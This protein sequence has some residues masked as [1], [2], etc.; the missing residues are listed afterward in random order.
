[1]VPKDV[2]PRE[3]ELRTNLFAQSWEPKLRELPGELKAMVKI[4]KKYGLR[5]EGLAFSRRILRDMPIWAHKQVN[6]KDLRKLAVK[7]ATTTC[8]KF[9]HRLRTVGDCEKM[10]GVLEDAS[11]RRSR[12]CSCAG[13]E[14]AI[15]EDRCTYPDRCFERARRLLDLLP[16]KW[17]PRGTHP[18]DYE[19]EDMREGQGAAQNA[20][21]FDRRVT[22]SGSIS[23]TYRIFTDHRPTYN[24]RLDMQ[25]RP[26]GESLT[27]ATDGS[28][29]NNGRGNTEAGAGVFV[30]AGHC[31]NRAVKLP[32]SFEHTNQTAEM[33]ATLVASKEF[34]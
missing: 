34:D 5:Q 6:Q 18:E 30:A 19:D 3:H 22:T 9:K 10:A 33:T 15:T 1:M 32:D 29:L 11:H 17:D 26:S 25:L 13:C 12:E 31:Q 14:R 27:V 7:S 24:G 28:C 23:D 8:L 4:T 16:P 21:L 20:T 2:Y